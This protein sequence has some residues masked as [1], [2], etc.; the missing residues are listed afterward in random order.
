MAI[1]RNRVIPCVLFLGLAPLLGCSSKPLHLAD[2]AAADAIVGGGGLLGAGG[3]SGGQTGTVLGGTGGGLGGVSGS[4]VGSGGAGA[5]GTAGTAGA[6][7]AGDAS[8]RG[9]TGSTGGAIA[10]L[11]ARTVASPAISSG[12]GS[13]VTDRSGNV[14]AAGS[15]FAPGTLDFGNGVTATAT[16]DGYNGLLVKYDAS[17]TPQWAHTG[18]PGDLGPLAMDSSGHIFALTTLPA[19]ASGVIDFH[20]V[21]ITKSGAFDQAVLVK[22]D[23]SGKAQ[24]ARTITDGSDNVGVFGKALAIDTNDNVYVAGVVED[25]PIRDASAA[26]AATSEAAR[27]PHLMSPAPQP[28][29]PAHALLV[30]F[31]SSGAPQWTRTVTA[32]SVTGDSPYSWFTALALDASGNVYV[33]GRIGS[34]LG[35]GSY[36]FG[37]GLVAAAPNPV[38]VRYSAAGIPE[39]VRTG[40]TGS[41]LLA[42]AVDS[43]GGVYAAGA[44][45]IGA[46]DFGNGVTATGTLNPDAF[47]GTAGPQYAVLVK[48]DPSG[49]TQWAQTVAKGGPS[50][51]FTSI[52]A[53][54]A[55]GVYAVGSA[56]GPGPYDFGNGASVPAGTQRQNYFLF[57][58]YSRSGIAEWARSSENRDSAGAELDAVTVDFTGNVYAAGVVGGPGDVDFGDGVTLSGLQAS[59]VVGWSALLVKYR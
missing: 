11:W 49:V 10:A 53:A 38:L 59:P 25:T 27:A 12:F 19:D 44:M 16:H 21:T 17:G 31:D 45:G 57:V 14:Y 54:P 51:Y 41:T 43:A 48:Y 55:G 15:L 39:W 40:A 30:R 32:I 50:S 4:S 46:H 20:G 47:T 5:G 3:T 34:P 6:V 35:S 26:A 29:N 42:L 24:W 28:V 18:T 7:D 9:E 52:T 2:A 22:Y 1:G 13:V 56:Y 58:K 8:P 36:D 37:N 23:S 33:A